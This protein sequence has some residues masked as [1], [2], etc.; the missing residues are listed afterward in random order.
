MWSLETEELATKD[1]LKSNAQNKMQKHFYTN[2]A[3]NKL[4]GNVFRYD[5]V[6]HVSYIFE[7][8]LNCGQSYG[9]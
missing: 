4:E 5:F 2:A 7:T 3:P 8:I 1:N 9:L 6:Q